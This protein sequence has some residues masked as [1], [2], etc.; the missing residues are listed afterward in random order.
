MESVNRSDLL[1]TYLGLYG[2]PDTLKKTDLLIRE[3]REGLLE[4]WEYFREKNTGPLYILQQPNGEPYIRNRI[5]S[6][7]EYDKRDFVRITYTIFPSIML[8]LFKNHGAKI[9]AA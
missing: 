4:I 3:L 7:Y 5:E 2:I 1:N 9:P 8:E 6:I